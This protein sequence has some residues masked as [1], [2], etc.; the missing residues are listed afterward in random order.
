[1]EISVGDEG[2]TTQAP[3]IGMGGAQTT[4]AQQRVSFMFNEDE[5]DN[6]QPAKESPLDR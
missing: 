5:D 1:M 4:R 3:N 2:G 6:N